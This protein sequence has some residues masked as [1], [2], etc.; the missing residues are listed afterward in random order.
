MLVDFKRKKLDKIEKMIMKLVDGDIKTTRISA[1]VYIGPVNIHS[2]IANIAD[3]EYKLKYNDDEYVYEYGVCDFPQQ[4]LD[5]YG[6]F[7]EEHEDHF[8]IT[9]ARIGKDCDWRWHKWG[10][11]IGDKN[12]QCEY[13]KDEDDS[14]QGVYVYHIYRLEK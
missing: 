11:Y 14:I 3:Y 8:C 12:P 10:I 4:V 5:K 7:L 1:G 6:K 13:L 2:H 9:F